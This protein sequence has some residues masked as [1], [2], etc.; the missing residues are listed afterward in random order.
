MTVKLLDSLHHNSIR[1]IWDKSKLKLNA[2]IIKTINR[3]IG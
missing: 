1:I 3:V 2:Y